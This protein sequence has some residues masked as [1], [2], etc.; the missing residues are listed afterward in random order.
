MGDNLQNEIPD[1]DDTYEYRSGHFFQVLV[2]AAG[3]API[4]AV[5]FAMCTVLE[6]RLTNEGRQLS[7]RSRWAKRRLANAYAWLDRNVGQIA[8]FECLECFRE[9]AN[10]P[11][12]AF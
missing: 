2:G 7:E 10:Q 8:D 4:A 12:P 11:A 5:L 3:M 6:D 9:V 1:E